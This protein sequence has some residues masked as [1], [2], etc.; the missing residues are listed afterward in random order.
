MGASLVGRANEDEVQILGKAEVK[1]RSEQQVRRG[2]IPGFY[3]KSDLL[4][5]AAYHN[6]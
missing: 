1:N 4:V 6:L 5:V 3:G 2:S